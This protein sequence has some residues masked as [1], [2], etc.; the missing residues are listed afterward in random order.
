M[1]KKSPNI[2]TSGMSN[3][4]PMNLKDSEYPLMLNGNIQTDISGPVTLTNE[5]SN[6]LCNKFPEGFK[7]INELY[8]PEISLTF[9][10]LVN[11]TPLTT[12]NSLTAYSI[13]DLVIHNNIKYKC[14]TNNSNQE[15]PN[16]LYWALY[17]SSQI[18]YLKEY[19]LVENTDIPGQ[20]P[21]DN[22]D[23]I[24]I[25]NT[26]LEK[27]TQEPIC[28]Y[29]CIT[30][31]DCLNFNIDFPI[32]KAVYKKDNCGSTLYFTEALNPV[33]ALKLT[34]D[35]KVDDTQRFIN[36]YE[37]DCTEPCIAPNVLNSDCECIKPNG[38]VD[39]SCTCCNPVYNPRCT[40]EDYVGEEDIDCLKI[41]LFPQ[42]G[43][44]CID[45][46]GVVPGGTL[47]AGTYQLA[48]C[49]A[50][51]NGERATRTFAC[52]NPMSVF[53]PG[54]TLTSQLDYPT[55]LA[56]KF[57]INDLDS[58]LYRFIDVFVVATI[59]SI[60]SYKQYETID[61]SSL[62]GGTLEYTVADFEKGKDVSID[63]LLQIF[64][65][66]ETAHEI[67]TSGNTLLLANLT[68]PR[69]LNLQKAV[70][71]LSPSLRWVTS[72]ANEWFYNDGAN[73]GAHRSF[74]RDEI[75]ALGLVLERNNTLDTC[76]YP[77]I[78]RDLNTAWEATYDYKGEWIPTMT[79]YLS[80]NDN[81]TSVVLYNGVYYKSLIDDNIGSAPPSTA[82]EALPISLCVN[83]TAVINNPDIFKTPG[84]TPP[85]EGGG[86]AFNLNWKTYNTACNYG[87]TC[88][89]LKSAPA[90][91]DG[92][93]V[94]Q[95]HSYRY[96][97]PSATANWPADTG[98]PYPEDVIFNLSVDYSTLGIFVGSTVNCS[99]FPTTLVATI[100][101]FGPLSTQ[102][103]I[104]VSEAL[105]PNLLP[106]DAI[107]I[108]FDINCNNT[109]CPTVEE[110]NPLDCY[111]NP[112]DKCVD[113]ILNYPTLLA[114]VSHCIPAWNS[115]TFYVLDNQVI[116]LGL[117][118]TASGPN[119]NIIPAGNPGTWTL[120]APQ[121]SIPP[122]P[123]DCPVWPPAG[124]TAPYVRTK[125]DILSYFNANGRYLLCIDATIVSYSD[126]LSDPFVV[127]N[128]S[129]PKKILDAS[130]KEW[131]VYDILD[132]KS[133]V[134]SSTDPTQD[135]MAGTKGPEDPV[136]LAG[137]YL[138]PSHGQLVSNYMFTG[139]NQPG[140]DP[141]NYNPNNGVV[142]FNPSSENKCNDYGPT[143]PLMYMLGHD[144]EP[145]VVGPTPCCTASGE[146]CF[147]SDNDYWNIGEGTF[148][149]R[150]GDTYAINDEV[151]YNGN[152]YKSLVG[153]NVGN[154]PPIIIPFIDAFWE[155][156]SEINNGK[157]ESYWF[158]F[159]ATAI[160]PT[161]IIKSKIGYKFG[162]WSGN[163]HTPATDDF[164]QQ[165]DFRI[166]VY[167]G[168]FN[169]VPPTWSSGVDFVNPATYHYTGGFEDQGILVIGDVAN[170]TGQTTTAG[171]LPLIAGTTYYVHMYLLPQA[172]DK[173]NKAPLGNPAKSSACVDYSGENG[174][175]CC[176]CYFANYAYLNLCMNSA[177]SDSK[178]L[179]SLK[180]TWEVDC[181]YTVYYR[182]PLLKDH[183]CLL[184]TFEYGAFAYWESLNHRYP[185]SPEV[186]GDLCQQPIRHFKFPDVLV[187]KLQDQDPLIP[188][189]L[190]SNPTG[191]G[192]FNSQRTAKIYPLSFR[193]EAEDVKAWLRWAALP[194]A[195]GGGELITQEELK[196]I[197]G[198]KL[199]RGNRVGNKSIVAK[200]L[201]FDMGK[202]SE[203]DY[204]NNS[205]S[206]IKT[207]YPNYPFNDLRQDPYL[208]KGGS[209]FT[210]PTEHKRWSFL[211]PD[212]TFNTPFLG[213]ELK[214]EAVNFGDALGNFYTVK[215]HPKY[216]LLSEG[217]IALAATLAGV[218][219]AADLLILIGN[220]LGPTWGAGVVVDYPVGSIVG[221]VGGFLAMVPN[222]FI[223]AKQ[224]RDI[225]VG[226]GVPQN[227]AKY[228]V[229]MGNYHSSGALGEVGNSGDKRRLITNST[230]LLA[231][232]LGTSDDGILSKINNYQRED[233]VYLY[234]RLKIDNYPDIMNPGGTYVTG[235]KP[236]FADTSR[237]LMTDGRFDDK[238]CATRDRQSN[239]ASFYASMKN[240]VPD[241]YGAIHDI[242]WL[243]TGSCIKIDWE[244]PQPEEK[245]NPIFGGDTFISRMTQKRKIPFFL[246][247]PVGAET[248][249]DFQYQHLSNIT[250]ATYYFNS[251]GE[252]V[253]SSSSIQFVPVEHNFDITSC[254]EPKKSLYLKGSMYLFSYGIVS[255][256]AESDFNLNFRYAQDTKAKDFYPHQS[257]LENWTQ[258]RNIPIE[259]PNAY[260]YNRTYSK[261]NKEN[262][263]CS[264]PVIYSNAGCITTYKNRVIN[265]IPDEDSDFYTDPWRVFLANDYHD[266]PLTNGQLVGMDGIEKEKV[267]LRFNN[268]SLVFNAYYTMTTDAG[269]A[270]IGT[271]SMFAQKPLEYAKTN[272]GFGGTEHHAFTSTQ[273]GHFW[274]DAQKGNVFMLPPDSG[275]EEIS[276]S[277]NTFFNNN[278]PF[279]ILKAFPNF[280][281]DNNYKDIGITLG[282]DNKFDRLLIT[283]LDYDLRAKYVGR[284]TYVDGVFYDGETVVLLTNNE[285]F[286]NKSWTIGYSPVTKSWI[287]YYS[288]VPNYY[289]SHDNYF[290]TGINYP[291][292]QNVQ[293]GVWNHLISNKS[294][295]VFYG[296]LYPFITDVVIK[297]ELINKQLHSIEYQADF[298]RFQNDYDY[299]YNT[300]VTFNKMVI[301]SEN[302][303]TGNL[304]LVPQ[305][306][307]NM[308]QGLLYPRVN[309]NSTTV[310]VTRKENNWRVNQFFDLV[311]NKQNNVPPMLYNCHPYLKEVNP[312][313]VDYGKPTFQKS[314]LTSD[315]FT[316]RFINDEYSNYKIINK[317][318]INNTIKSDS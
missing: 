303:N 249:V 262:F 141:E 182:A 242:E 18:G 66:Y 176:P 190:T 281:V 111:I 204:T 289:I 146:D 48:A 254:N 280:P 294:Y 221:M 2:P 205:Y 177:T 83:D 212:T 306:Q 132:I 38:E 53:D 302:R 30:N 217:G 285:Y 58:S 209:P 296:R 189:D 286:C 29:N 52:S 261:Q 300:G 210:L 73:A 117:V 268:T 90:C 140:T 158:S 240:D 136:C 150:V 277:L 122:I 79:Y 116:Y 238:A 199:V 232:N 271:G 156:I 84:C 245:C 74:L 39:F 69:D 15:P 5:N 298:L 166:D 27:I 169:L 202:Y 207:Y 13:D 50:D 126:S 119:T 11:P 194:I 100:T 131:Y 179:V 161:V 188:L 162:D 243:Y 260:F 250:N 203:Y 62:K 101:A 123:C 276:S 78:G 72:E 270:Q 115:S 267:I 201:L 137:L 220:L 224:W 219:L 293:T 252:S 196:S 25:E 44:I 314:R 256:I 191:P 299:F 114:D 247:N 164:Q 307:N 22:C 81:Q 263:F 284:V 312:L 151:S 95:C 231:G 237:F 291:Q 70:I 23:T 108:S 24:N 89:P 8:V 257:D 76:V 138:Y 282:W 112:D 96:S 37:G 218:Q 10:W 55:G 64:P 214:F 213:T 133:K 12:W 20:D 253:A 46:V 309:T 142:A 109:I 103:T 26:P 86:H 226:F 60:S 94:I 305:P 258:E 239:V 28:E 308:A 121:P 160:Q 82:W 80:N 275:L 57:S 87:E 144:L 234:T 99:S 313:A 36:H 215:G 153:G 259:N 195:D 317:W 283:K 244:H 174:G 228:Y 185:N 3:T 148:T 59:N 186:W 65:V 274:V 47:Q 35:Y 180:E 192:P 92:S 297:D 14:T 211:S 288:F 278:L 198:Y 251:V 118:Y 287:S 311:K 197:T 71:G 222:F 63:D 106:N 31:S 32:R 97:V 241:Q 208:N 102:L 173:V 124:V 1:A 225:I 216:T 120:D 229:A 272:L 110:C 152:R 315:Y 113:P 42:V 45:L 147:W 269:V 167:E 178:K 61:I 292:Y 266:F 235:D 77:L 145:P 134:I 129:T 187:S 295:Q 316:L 54:Q 265:S 172:V 163:G 34:E 159:V 193:V 301:W 56:C 310:L 183:G 127:K 184:Q 236:W 206:N 248:G 135:F 130:T 157:Y 154:T 170:S 168:D 104:S 93:E 149:W 9:V 17:S 304:E 105:P 273:F 255:F 165:G 85:I 41:R 43:H 67:T 264:Q 143:A 223:Y 246:D 51:Q 233:S 98:G 230:Y 91:E 171:Q 33:R 21:C 279:F 4:H 88:D 19:V 155:R 16:S 290:Q 181:N 49:Y 40:D 107:T 318:F 175:S 128:S 68:S 139:I 200:G 75:Y 227:F 7:V 125:S 6:Y